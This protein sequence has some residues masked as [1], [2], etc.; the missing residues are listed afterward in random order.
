MAWGNNKK[1]ASKQWLLKVDYLIDNEDEV[2][3]VLLPAI[4]RKQVIALIVEMK[5]RPTIQDV[6]IVHNF[7]EVDQQKRKR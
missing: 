4:P 7:V 6:N 1:F 3:Y 2:G 5:N